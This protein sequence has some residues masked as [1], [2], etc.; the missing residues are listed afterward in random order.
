MSCASFYTYLPD[1]F[2]IFRNFGIKKS[3]TKVHHQNVPL[4][5][6]AA[7]HGT[8]VKGRYK[9]ALYRERDVRLWFW[10]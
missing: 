7:V 4:K 1:T 3:Q 5:R 8:V 2:G 6:M 9:D 10:H